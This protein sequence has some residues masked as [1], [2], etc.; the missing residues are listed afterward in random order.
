MVKNEHVKQKAEFMAK[1]A[2]LGRQQG[3]AAASQEAKRVLNKLIEL[4]EE[5]GMVKKL[6]DAHIQMVTVAGPAEAAHHES[7][8]HGLLALQGTGWRTTVWLDPL[9]SDTNRLGTCSSIQSV[10]SRQPV[11]CCSAF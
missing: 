3:S 10:D 6:L 8:V 11:C 4:C 5:Y 1:V 9:S 2:R 7:A